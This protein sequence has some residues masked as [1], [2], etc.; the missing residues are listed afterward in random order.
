MGGKDADP[1]L[2]SLKEG[3]QSSTKKELKVSKK[4]NILDKRQAGK[5]ASVG[6]GGGGSGGSTEAVHDDFDDMSL[7]QT[8]STVSSDLK[9]SYCA[10]LC[11][12]AA[13][14]KAKAV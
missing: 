4:A 7:T 11:G 9:I 14:L 8:L 1:L 13:K 3:Y 2:I 12:L 6:G 5:P 10:D